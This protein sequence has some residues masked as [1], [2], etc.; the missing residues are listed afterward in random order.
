[1]K[2]CSYLFVFAAIAALAAGCGSADPPD[3]ETP[4]G[5]VVPGAS[6][7]A[8][9]LSADELADFPMAIEP[10]Q[11][12]FPDDHGPHLRFRNEWWYFTGNLDADSGER[13][14]FEL[15]LFRFAL[16]PDSSAAEPQSSNSAWR[17]N[18]VYIG[19]FAITDPAGGVFYATERYARGA[20]GL[21]GATTQPVRVWVYDWQISH[22]SAGDRW[23][24]KATDSSFSLDLDLAAVK[25]PVLNG[26]SGLSQKSSE[27][28][29][30]SYY[31]S[32]SRLGARGHVTLGAERYAV[33]GNAWLDR[34]WGSSAL[35]AEQVG[36][37]WF[38]LQ[39]DDG[40][41]LMY[42]N[43]RRNDGSRDVQSA[44]TFV[45]SDGSAV[46]LGH[47]DVEVIASRYWTNDV[48]DRY[49]VG[50]TVTVRKLGLSAN[51]EP[52]MDDQ[53]LKTQVRYWEGAVDVAA[54]RHD[55]ILNGRGYVEL[56]GYSN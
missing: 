31:Y 48:G 25:A 35:S 1:M 2:K 8:D 45:R 41:E 52:V 11:F 32:V 21:A 27:P 54:T 19:H 56:T 26:D 38:A 39:F 17:T 34:E 13:F 24:L 55:S 50:W 15:T 42:Y 18:Q 4:V 33:D 46:R 22:E 9:L 3:S 12:R 7:L 30:A 6:R 16:N 44:G 36:W 37:D 47:D 29:N 10:R 14:G 23:S 40:S 53:E 5:A 51:V 49:P 20:A 43:L 28:G